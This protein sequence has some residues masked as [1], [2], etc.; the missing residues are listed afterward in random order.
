MIYNSKQ[1]S[2]QI[3]ICLIKIWDPKEGSNPLE[4]PDDAMLI[5]E[6]EQIEIEESYRK[7]IGTASVKFPRGTVIR[8]TITQYNEEDAAKDKL[9]EAS[10]SSGGAVEEV[11]KSISEVAKTSNFKVGQRIRIYLGYTDDP[12]IAQMAKAN[13]INGN[14]SIFVSKSNREDYENAQ[15]FADEANRALHKMFDGYITKISVD[16]PIELHCENL[17]SKLKEIT[18]GKIK[19]NKNSTVNQLL[20]KEYADNGAKKKGYGLLE[21]TGLS[22]H[23]KAR[24]QHFD[25]AVRSEERRV[26]KECRSRWSPYH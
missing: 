14:S 5:T 18:C 13:N 15:Y 10:V 25:L 9:L 16:A 24:N 1:P 3:L 7:L 11:R 22:L 21:G 2:F 17:A 19:L 20:L 8:K 12:K 6:C 26:G 23:P 4:I